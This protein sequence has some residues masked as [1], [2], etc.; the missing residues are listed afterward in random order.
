MFISNTLFGAAMGICE[1]TVSSSWLGGTWRRDVLNLPAA[2]PDL[3]A[4][5]STASI[6]YL[7][8]FHLL[9][10]SGK[11]IGAMVAHLFL[12]CWA[13]KEG[14]LVT[15]SSSSTRLFKQTFGRQGGEKRG[16]GR[17]L[18][19][20][21]CASFCPLATFLSTKWMRVGQWSWGVCGLECA[22]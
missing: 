19:G 16:G 10:V 12:Q 2:F 4:A 20:P 8:L 6:T 3:L 9:R 5:Y 21:C 14:A 7:V 1:T 13:R 11:R 18:E 17:I 15:S 22:Y